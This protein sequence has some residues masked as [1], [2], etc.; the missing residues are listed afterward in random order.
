MLPQIFQ[1]VLVSIIRNCRRYVKITAFYRILSRKTFC[2]S[3]LNNQI[4]LAVLTRFY[5]KLSISFYL[6]LER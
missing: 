2:F 6:A 1:S 5:V 4:A 3:Y